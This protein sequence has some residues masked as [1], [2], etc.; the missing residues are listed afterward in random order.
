MAQGIDTYEDFKTSV[1]EPDFQEFM[2]DKG[3]L[4]KAWHCAGSLFHL[5][6][7]V[8]GAHKT[9]IDAKYTYKDDGG[10]EG[11][12]RVPD[13]YKTDDGYRLDKWVA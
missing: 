5:H 11:H 7:W 3:N 2:A 10:L 1:A 12:C 13:G 8:Y 6:D 9:S 4:R